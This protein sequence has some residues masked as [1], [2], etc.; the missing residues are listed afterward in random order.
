MDRQR[1]PEVGACRVCWGLARKLMWH[2]AAHEMERGDASMSCS[3]FS[4]LMSLRVSGILRMEGPGDAQALRG[5]VHGMAT[6]LADD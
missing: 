5:V 1:R 4:V 3:L 6:V 2:E